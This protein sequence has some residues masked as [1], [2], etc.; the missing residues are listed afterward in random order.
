MLPA[1]SAYD[2]QYVALA[3]ALGVPLVTTDGRIKRSKEARC[4]VL[5]T[6][7]RNST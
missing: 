7:A 1:R 6:H 3:E 5:D 4:E 2:A